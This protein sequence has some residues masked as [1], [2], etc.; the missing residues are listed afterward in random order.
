MPTA[1]LLPQQQLNSYN[2]A[3]LQFALYVTHPFLT[4]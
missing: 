2:V 4:L 1:E 3:Q